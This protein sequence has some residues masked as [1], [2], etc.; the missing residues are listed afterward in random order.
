[1]AGRAVTEAALAGRK[2]SLGKVLSCPY[3]APAP[4]EGS[5]VRK[6]PLRPGDC[7][8]C[9]GCLARAFPI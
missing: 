7:S 3:P 1:M 8:T 9:A 4:Y 5:A 2:Q 6:P